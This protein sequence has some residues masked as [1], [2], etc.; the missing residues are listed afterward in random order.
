MEPN[1][2]RQREEIWLSGI[3]GHRK[4]IGFYFKYTAKPQ[5]DFGQELIL[6]EGITL[7]ALLSIAI[8][9]GKV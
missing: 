9:L 7:A 2:D 3:A 8:I 4:E 1:K 5:Q 6:I